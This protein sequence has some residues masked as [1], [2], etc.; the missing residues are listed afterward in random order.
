M[1]TPVNRGL[2]LLVEDDENDAYF[3]RRAFG[4]SGFANPLHV[5]PDGLEAIHY[6]EGRQHYADRQRFPLPDLIVL[7]LNTPRRHGIEVLKWVRARSELQRVPVV[8][9][10]SSASDVD[11]VAAYGSGANSYLVK[12]A[13]PAGLLHAVQMITTYWLGLNRCPGVWQAGDAATA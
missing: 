5:A 1:I 13:E 11:L 2:V 7:D 3:F 6:L 8:V 10:T 4:K 9:L 12:P